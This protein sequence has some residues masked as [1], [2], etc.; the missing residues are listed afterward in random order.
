[1]YLSASGGDAGVDG[2]GLTRLVS[3]VPYRLT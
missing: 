3:P 1:M 2:A